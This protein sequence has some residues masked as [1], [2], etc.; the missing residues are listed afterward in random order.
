MRPLPLLLST[1][2]FVQSHLQ[3]QDIVE[4]ATGVHFPAS[5]TFLDR[6]GEPLT[7]VGTAVRFREGFKFYTLC[8]YVNMKE[9]RAKLKGSA[10][11]PETLGRLLIQG[12]VSHVF[13]TNFYVGV[14]GNRRLDFLKENVLKTWPA[15]DV[16][17]PQVQ[18]FIQF[19][20]EDLN[21]GD[22]TEVWIDAKG[23][24]YGHRIGHPPV[25]AKSPMLGKAFSATYFGPQAMDAQ[26]KKQLLEGLA[27]ALN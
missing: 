10:R 23:T 21:R 2:C 12:G 6:G 22:A 13:V 16:A 8:L 26:F 11:D 27:K 20:H 5:R 15:F 19:F 24:I 9:L 1:L 25:Q 3:G 7:A 14:A 17:D 4:P 18:D